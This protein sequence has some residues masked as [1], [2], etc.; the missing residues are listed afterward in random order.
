VTPVLIPQ[1]TPVL[2]YIL[3]TISKSKIGNHEKLAEQQYLPQGYHKTKSS[4]S[5]F[6]KVPS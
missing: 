3:L 2:P 1:D 5:F 4:A 6:F